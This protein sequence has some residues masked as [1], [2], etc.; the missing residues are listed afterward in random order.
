MKGHEFREAKTVE[1]CTFIE[2][3]VPSERG[4]DH[5]DRLLK[6]EHVKFIY[7]YIMLL[8]EPVRKARWGFIAQI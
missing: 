2:T 4:T 7:I 6:G 8:N 5:K 1:N 3:K